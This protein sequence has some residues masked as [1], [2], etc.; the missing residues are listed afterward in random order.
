MKRAHRLWAE[1]GLAVL[2]LAVA[3]FAFLPRFRNAQLLQQIQNRQTELQTLA[4]A[5]MAYEIQHGPETQ[6]R[7]NTFVLKDLTFVGDARDLSTIGFQQPENNHPEFVSTFSQD[8]L[9]EN[10]QEK[11]GAAS[12]YPDFSILRTI[13]H[14][15]L[16]PGHIRIELAWIIAAPVPGRKGDGRFDYYDFP[17]AVGPG[18]RVQSIREDRFDSS[19]G[20][21][22]R[23]MLFGYAAGTFVGREIKKD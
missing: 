6:S 15:S 19:N 10:W 18:E 13:G 9:W 17:R 22:S 23:G 4:D 21:R 12:N 20:L 11:I 8:G 2:I 5:L 16:K 1:T 7:T 14:Y 3:V